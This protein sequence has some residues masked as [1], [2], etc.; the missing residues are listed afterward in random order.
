MSLQWAGLQLSQMLY[1]EIVDLSKCKTLDE[2]FKWFKILI[3]Q[4]ENRAKLSLSAS[5]I[6]VVYRRNSGYRDSTNGGNR[7]ASASGSTTAAGGK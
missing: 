1:N 5:K 6:Y 4:K 3:D 7:S 2:I